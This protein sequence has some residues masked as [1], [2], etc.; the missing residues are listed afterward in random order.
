M[1]R[2]GKIS[3]RPLKETQTHLVNVKCFTLIVCVYYGTMGLNILQLHDRNFLRE[4]VTQCII[5]YFPQHWTSVLHLVL[6]LS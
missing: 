1:Q 6:S 5:F 2:N 4:S 3:R